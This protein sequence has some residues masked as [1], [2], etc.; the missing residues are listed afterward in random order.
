VSGQRQGVLHP[1]GLLRVGE[2]FA[3]HH[4][5]AVP[6]GHLDE[7]ALGMAAIDDQRFEE[8]R[9]PAGLEV[10][11]IELHQH[12]AAALARRGVTP[13]HVGERQRPFDEDVGHRAGSAF[14]RGRS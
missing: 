5:A 10:E 9:P 8:R 14:R 1:G 12:L 6:R 13:C 7:E 11:A 3:A 2:R 4:D